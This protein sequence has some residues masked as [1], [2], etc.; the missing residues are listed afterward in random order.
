LGDTPAALGPKLEGALQA[1]LAPHSAIPLQL[2]GVGAFP[3]VRRPNVVWAGIGGAVT[4]LQRIQAGIEAALEN[5]GIAP[6]PKPFH[7]HL[8]LGR[9]RRTANREQQEQLGHAIRS[10]PAPAPVEWL[11]E[12]IVLFS[13][14]L[15]SGGPVYTKVVDCRLQIAD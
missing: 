8:T 12:R 10:L 5:L 11:A 13:S 7:P 3:N 4:A 15:R 14:A 9:L 6:D 2:N 1:A